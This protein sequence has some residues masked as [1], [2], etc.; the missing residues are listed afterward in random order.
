MT[1]ETLLLERAKYLLDSVSNNVKYPTVEGSPALP[2]E[3]TA[4]VE[5]LRKLGLDEDA[6]AMRKD[7]IVYF[8][9]EVRFPN[10]RIAP[11][12]IEF[13]SKARELFG[14]F[15]KCS[16]RKSDSKIVRQRLID[17][18]DGLR[19][20]FKKLSLSQTKSAAPTIADDL[21]LVRENAILAKLSETQ[22]S[23][24]FCGRIWS[25][26]RQQQEA[27]IRE[28]SRRRTPGRVQIAEAF[29]TAKANGWPE[30][31][32]DEFIKCA[33]EGIK[34]EKPWTDF[35]EGSKGEKIPLEKFLT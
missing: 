23:Y 33:R 9:H 8:A 26:Y 28:G 20:T 29:P 5:Y 19:I 3:A 21:A 31:Q 7:L 11:Q 2:P 16:G 13:R 25:E 34:K 12:L 27:L 32:L 14:P 4:L 30:D 18:F 6:D 35:V 22:R 15:P 1:V 17:Q 24:V 10:S